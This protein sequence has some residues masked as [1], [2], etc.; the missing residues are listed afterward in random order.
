MDL[1]VGQVLSL[2][3]RFNN[4]GVIS[5]S[6]H[7]YLIVDIDEDFEVIEV[8]QIDSL[9]GKEYKAAFTTNKTILCNNP[10]ETVIDKDSYVQLDNKFTLELYDGLL[11]YRRQKD[12][13][14]ENKLQSV[15]AAYKEYQQK[16]HLN[17]NKIVY[18]SREEIETLN[19]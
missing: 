6:K 16:H 10:F 11:Q 12:K 7:P 13:L 14:S 19:N 9:K 18:M 8:V 5:S 15:I 2:R 1:E 4:S 3:I 17:E